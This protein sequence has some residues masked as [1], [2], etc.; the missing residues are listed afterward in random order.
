M[1]A[2]ASCSIGDFVPRVPREASLF[3]EDKGGSIILDMIVPQMALELPLQTLGGD[4]RVQV[5][6]K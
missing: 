6:G 5:F 1:L 2:K 4:F 3:L